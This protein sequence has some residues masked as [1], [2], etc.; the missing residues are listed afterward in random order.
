M[1]KSKLSQSAE[2][3]F[4]CR[5]I[6]RKKIFTLTRKMK[7]DLDNRDNK[8][9]CRYYRTKQAWENVQDKLDKYQSIYGLITERMNEL[10]ARR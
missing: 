2:Y 4:S 1:P 10:E 5:E 7:E 9:P 6:I 8:R 3:W